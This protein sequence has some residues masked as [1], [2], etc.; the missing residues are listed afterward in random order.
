[1]GSVFGES[2]SAS[3]HTNGSGYHAY[4]APHLVCVGHCARAT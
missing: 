1:M 4:A 2:N 3:N